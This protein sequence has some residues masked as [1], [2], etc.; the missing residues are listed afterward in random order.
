MDVVG[1]LLRGIDRRLM[2]EQRMRRV[3]EVLQV[4]LPIA[5]VGVLEHAARR[6]PV[7]VRRAVDHVVE[8]RRH[9]AEKLLQA[10]TI[11]RQASEHEP[12]IA[13]HPRH[14]GHRDLGILGIEWRG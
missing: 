9:V 8:R 12:A 1:L 10:R 4:E 6:A 2:N 5:L 13:R 3:A 7:A 14:A 11:L